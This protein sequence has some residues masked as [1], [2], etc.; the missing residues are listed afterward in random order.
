MQSSKIDF[1][2][3][4]NDIVQF[5][6]SAARELPDS[7][8]EYLVNEFEF[9]AVVLVKIKE[10]GFEFLGKSSTAKKSYNHSSQLN[11]LSC[12]LVNSYSTETIFEVNPQCEFKSSDV[13]LNEGCLQ[14]SITDDERVLLKIAKKSNFSQKDKDNIVIIGN[15]IRNLL[16]LWMGKKGSL[17]SSVSEIIASIGPELRTPTNSILGFAS[18]LGEES[19]SQTQID[20]L[21]TLKENTHDLLFLLNDLIDLAKIETDR[22]SVELTQINIK[23]FFGEIIKLFEAKID[24]NR[25]EIISNIDSELPESVKVNLQKLQYIITNLFTNSL[26][27]TEKGKISL[28][29]FSSEKDQL[30]IRISDTGVGIPSAILKDIFN[31]FSLVDQYITTIGNTTGLGLTLVKR[32]IDFVNGE[33]DIS[34]TVGKGTTFNLTIPVEEIPDIEEQIS[35]LPKPDFTNKV[36]VVEDD[37]ATSKLLGNYL[38]KWGYEPTIVN[39]ASQTLKILE[40]LK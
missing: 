12:N 19:L 14:I 15:T 31:P 8:C 35:N 24:R 32:Y 2:S 7:L 36:L 39:S 20:Y 18:L 38:N 17:S 9:E 23:Q 33:L 37:Y 13:V 21:N 3:K 25:I 11:C 40:T 22:S 30:R 1:I 28:S 10:K 5:A 26:R 29:V 4:Y 34:S 27:L 16:R 6:L